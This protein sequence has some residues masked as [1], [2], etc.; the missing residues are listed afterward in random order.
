[1]IEFKGGEREMNS[2]SQKETVMMVLLYIN[3]KK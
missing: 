2:S 1:V 3:A